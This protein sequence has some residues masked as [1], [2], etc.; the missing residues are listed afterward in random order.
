MYL[1]FIFWDSFFNGII[2]LTFFIKALKLLCYSAF[3]KPKL[4]ENKEF[5]WER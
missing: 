3:T 5:N 4:M 2:N 1:I